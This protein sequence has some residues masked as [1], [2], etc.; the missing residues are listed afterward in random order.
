MTHFESYLL[1]F[2]SLFLC[3]ILKS[4]A[5]INNKNREKKL[6]IIYN[7]SKGRKMKTFISNKYIRGLNSF[8]P[9]N[10]LIKTF[11]FIDIYY[12]SIIALFDYF[13]F[14]KCIHYQYRI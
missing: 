14:D 11:F 1:F 5:H 8:M 12:L 4:V 9:F 3:Y 6:Y 2:F 13:F 10:F 7:I